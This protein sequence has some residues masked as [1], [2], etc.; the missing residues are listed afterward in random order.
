MCSCRE[1]CKQIR[2]RRRCDHPSDSRT[3]NNRPSKKLHSA[4]ILITSLPVPVSGTTPSNVSVTPVPLAVAAWLIVIEVELPTAVIVVFDG[5]LPPSIFRPTS[6]ATK[7]A[8]ALVTVVLVEVV[9]PSVTCRPALIGP[10]ATVF[11]PVVVSTH[12]G[13]PLVRQI[14]LKNPDPPDS[15]TLPLHGSTLTFAGELLH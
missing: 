11:V 7:L 8:V 9:T 13:T 5:M 10:H 14:L 1:L 3:N 15:V 12:F 4:F 6:P 2:T